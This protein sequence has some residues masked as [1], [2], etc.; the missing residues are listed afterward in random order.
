MSRYDLLV[1]GGTVVL[2][3]H[4][5]I[6]ADLA[7][8][9]GKVAALADDI[10]AAEADEVVDARGKVVLPGAVDA[11]F[12][13][14][15]YRDLALD[16]FEETRSSLVGGATTVLSYFRTGSHYLD[17][18]GPY[19]EI[20]PE[21]LNAVAGRTWTDYAFHLAPM[22]VDQIAE[23]PML[24]EEHRVTSFK[25]Y[26]FYKGFD[27]AAN[28]RDARSFT[29][30]DEY[31]LGHLYLLMEQITAVQKANP[32]KRLSVSLH[33]EQSELMRVF[34]DRVRADGDPQTLR[35]YH[36][37][38]PPLTERV[39]IGEA[40]TL[41]SHTGTNLNLLHLSSAE[42]VDAVALARR[43]FGGDLRAETTLH[44]LC[45]DH[46]TLDAT[47]SLGGKVNPPIR[48]KADNEALWR[49]AAEGTIDW[50]ASDHACCMEAE[51][52]DQLWPARPGF[53]GTALLY[54]VLFSE[55]HRKRGLSLSRIAELAS[56]N[57]ARAYNLWGRKGSLMVGFDADLTVVDPELAQPVTN[58]V[59]LSGQ[60][61]TPF[62]GVELTG[63]PV[64]TAVGGQVRFRDGETVGEPTGRYAR[65]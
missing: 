9:N 47:G 51:K 15:I 21:V 46:D 62:E 5:D 10:P 54:P 26:M 27:L 48:T 33:C 20:F 29:M 44:H 25:Y 30:G 59:C 6:R 36:E 17:R 40:T 39:A 13:L 61:H 3:F 63:W 56:A 2:P 45:L 1:K 34:I 32:D 4:G 23:I 31:D 43:S 7:V 53:G 60:D 19:K 57:P 35:A 42:A 52:G 11:H 65:H 12:H 38:R 14:G 18:T 37:G 55:G 41:A 24:V 8:S 64:V 49:H 58:E 22:T 16:A 28:S 50:V